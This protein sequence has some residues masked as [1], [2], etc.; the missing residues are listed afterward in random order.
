[1]EGAPYECGLAYGKQAADLIARAVEVYFNL[2]AHHAGL[3]KDQSLSLSTLFLPAIQEHLPSLEQEMQGL[4]EG[5]GISFE[6]VLFLNCRTEVL[7]TA[8]LHECTAIAAVPPATDPP[9][10]LLGQTWDWLEATRELPLVLKVRQPGQPQVVTLVEAGQLA[11]VGL[12]S[13]GFGLC[14]TWLEAHHRGRGLPVHLL[15]RAMLQQPSV[16]AAMNL[17][18]RVP[19]AAAAGYLLASHDGFAIGLEAAAEGLGWIEPD[20]GLVVHT[21]HFLANHLR[22]FDRGLLQEGAD[23]LIRRQRAVSLLEPLR[24]SINRE[25]L[26]RVQGDT[27]CAPSATSRAPTGSA[28]PLEDYV[29][30]AGVVMDLTLGEMALASGHP[31]TAVYR[32]VHG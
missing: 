6:E 11:K 24:G 18:F 19:R 2:A 1:M 20:Q 25:A 15:C 14:L 21:N 16:E 30:L 17:L 22:P 7:S 23:S 13:A 12:S 27:A 29:T 3:D 32:R 9:H 28:S 5:A 31:P 4:A 10:V 8:P 26:Q